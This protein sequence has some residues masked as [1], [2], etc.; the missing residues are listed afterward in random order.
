M[1]EKFHE[2]MAGVNPI[3]SFNAS[4]QAQKDPLKNQTTLSGMW[5]SRL[6]A[7][8]IATEQAGSAGGWRGMRQLISCSSIEKG[9][10]EHWAMRLL[11]RIKDRSSLETA[12][13]I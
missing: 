6:H 5:Y 3:F 9:V 11:S 1:I 2:K 7:D 8:F 12:G 4:R 10:Y 13:M